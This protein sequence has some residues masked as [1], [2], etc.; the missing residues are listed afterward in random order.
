VKLTPQAFTPLRVDDSI[1]GRATTQVV[2]MFS[3]VRRSLLSTVARRN[4]CA[5]VQDIKAFT[6][7]PV[8]CVIDSH[9]RHDHLF[10]NQ[11][12]YGSISA[13]RHFFRVL[14]PEASPWAHVSGV[15]GSGRVPQAQR[16]RHGA[17]TSEFFPV[18][19]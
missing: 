3:M 14:H 4:R 19:V 1:G 15:S 9:F 17:I 5:L 16:V 13:V 7:K 11:N 18:T 2:E 10:G 12:V 6:D 8:R